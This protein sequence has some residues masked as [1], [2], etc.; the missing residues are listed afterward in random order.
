MFARF[1]EYL[2][3]EEVVEDVKETCLHEFFADLDGMTCIRCQFQ[4]PDETS[5]F[6]SNQKRQLFSP[7]I[8]K[9]LESFNL[10]D[11]ITEISN[12]YFLQVCGSKVY[13]G[14][15]RKAIICACIYH[16]Y[17]KVNDFENFETISKKFGLT[18]RKAADGFK[19][20]KIKI[21]ETRNATESASDIAKGIMRQLQLKMCPKFDKFLR[22]ENF[23]SHIK[24]SKRTK[25]IISGLIF[26]FIQNEY[27]SSVKLT[28]FC[29]K[30]ELNIGDLEKVI[31]NNVY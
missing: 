19:L 25:L 31:N 23:N 30:L 5:N 28:D 8:F 22:S 29:E 1:E 9:E 15:K 7:S 20:V 24:I 17:L 26:K 27:K 16:A 6:I 10:G 12:D 2:E 18:Y 14:D 4:K 21:S 13:R 3:S 11:K